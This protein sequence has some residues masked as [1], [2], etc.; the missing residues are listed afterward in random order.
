M[1]VTS[2]EEYLKGRSASCCSIIL[3]PSP[4]LHGVQMMKGPSDL[5]I[6]TV[7]IFA[8]LVSVCQATWYCN[9]EGT[10]IMVI[11]GHEFRSKQTPQQKGMW[12]EVRD[13]R[14]W[15][16]IVRKYCVYL[17]YYATDTAICCRREQDVRK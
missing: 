7:Y 9:S 2:S 4:R 13:L 12:T 8:M 14:F 5:K 3:H 10:I 6:E 1:G 15:C 11:D 17:N 16:P